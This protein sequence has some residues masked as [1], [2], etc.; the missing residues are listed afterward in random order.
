MEPNV[1][2][3]PSLGP[4]EP[5]VYSRFEAAKRA[6]VSLSHLDRQV[7]LGKVPYFR[8][9]RKV[10]FPRAKFDYWCVHRDGKFPPDTAGGPR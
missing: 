5:L 6:K 3:N 9:G 1:H 4:Y 10:L 7:K 8:D 2:P